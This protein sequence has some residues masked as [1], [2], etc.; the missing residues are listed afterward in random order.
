MSHRIEKIRTVKTIKSLPECTTMQMPTTSLYETSFYAPLR[1]RKGSLT[2]EASIVVPL[3]ISFLLIFLLFFRLLE[4]ET[5]V[6]EALDYASRSAST[7]TIFSEEL[8]PLVCARGF[9]QSA[10]KDT[11]PQDSFLK[12]GRSGITLLGSY[13][14]GPYLYL[15][16]T[17]YVKFPGLLLKD[18]YIL[19]SQKS[20]SRFW[21][22][23]DIEN[24]EYV[25]I[26]SAGS[27]YHTNKM[28][29]SLNI[30][31]EAVKYAEI[32][33]LRNQNGG[34]YRACSDCA[35]ENSSHE[36]V[37]ITP[38]GE[39]FHWWIDC[40]HLKRTIKRIPKSEIGER[41]RCK[42]CTE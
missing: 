41:R 27:V 39:C 17:Y 3:V 1:R 19:V 22:G 38:Y 24:V 18:K 34:K 16:A 37:Y 21:V 4:I 23:E 30:Q 2:V 5:G 31:V 36:T 29:K 26:T 35:E 13:V 14:D 33:G 7:C 20:C 12:R 40:L 28:C 11:L 10:L 42:L 9:F 25:Y 32:E 8:E 6:K 15:Q